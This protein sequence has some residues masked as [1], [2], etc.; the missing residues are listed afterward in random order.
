MNSLLM[1][2]KRQATSASANFGK[3]TERIGD[4]IVNT[5]TFARIASHLVAV[6]QRF[7]HI[8]SF[9]HSFTH[10]NFKMISNINLELID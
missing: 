10:T 7:P 4:A 8:H 6:P 3:Q 5:H 9:I 1:C 2:E